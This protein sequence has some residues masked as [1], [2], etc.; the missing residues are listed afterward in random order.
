MGKQTRSRLNKR[1]GKN[2]KWGRIYEE[3]KQILVK[4]RKEKIKKLF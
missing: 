4:I 1:K 2:R 3:K